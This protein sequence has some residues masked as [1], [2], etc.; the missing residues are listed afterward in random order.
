MNNKGFS[1]IELVIAMGISSIVLLMVSVML[2]RGTTIFREESD[3]TNIRN[4]YQ[5]IRNQLDQAI[6]EA[7]SLV[8]ETQG[9]DLIIYTGEVDADRNFTAASISTEKVITYDTVTNS[10]YISNTYDT[11]KAPGNILT[12]IVDEFSLEI[13]NDKKT[14]IVDGTETAYYVNPVSVNISLT[15]EN[16]RTSIDTEFTI[17]FRNRLSKI[18]MYTTAN[19]NVRLNAATTIEEYRVK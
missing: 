14:E 13:S 2:V 17:N 11:H 4:D 16:K 9:T 18:A 12:D 10:L 8:V 5:L 6:M 19:G 7:K 15:L 3:D 1:L